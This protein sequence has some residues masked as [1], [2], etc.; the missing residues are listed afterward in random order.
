MI[1]TPLPVPRRLGWS[2]PEV[3]VAAHPKRGLGERRCG[4]SVCFPTSVTTSPSPR[5]EA[6]VRGQGGVSGRGSRHR[7]GLFAPGKEMLAAEMEPG[8]KTY[9]A[10]VMAC[11]S[12]DQ[13]QQ[14]LS[15]LGDL[16]DAGLVPDLFCYNIQSNACSKGGQWQRALALLR[17][18]C[19]A[20]LEPD[21]VSFN[22]GIG[23]CEKSGEWQQALS[24]LCSLC[25][26]K[27]EPDSV[28]YSLGVSSC[29]EG[30]QMLWV[31]PLLRGLSDSVICNEFLVPARAKHV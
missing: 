5:H 27:V 4:S 26:F 22:I 15:S 29:E 3:L 13:W 25:D 28:S 12:G 2:R 8:M 9:S 6:W 20:S 24:L 14:A 17:E 1:P 19:E 10:C 11:A 30:W 18:L 21:L 7:R 23:A 16:R 31:L